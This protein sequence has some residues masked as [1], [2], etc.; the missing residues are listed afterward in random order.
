[1][2]KHS[3]RLHEPNPE[4]CGGFFREI[5][6]QN[7]HQ[8][9]VRTSACLSAKTGD[10]GLFCVK[11]GASDKY[12]VLLSGMEEV[13]YHN[14]CEYD[15]SIG[16]GINGMGGRGIGYI[17]NISADPWPTIWFSIGP[18]TFRKELI[19]SHVEPALHVRYTLE[20]GASNSEL[21]VRPLLAFRNS[22]SFNRYEGS[23]PFNTRQ[24]G[25][26][27]VQIKVHNPVLERLWIQCSGDSSFAEVPEWRFNIK[28][29]NPY[30]EF[31]L[32]TEDLYSPGAF[33]CKLPLAGSVVLSF[34][35]LQE[36]HDF[37]PV[38]EMILVSVRY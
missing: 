37:P 14:H 22:V 18:V 13:L 12:Q 32:D 26:N 16:P 3:S 8:V 24:T 30:K 9:M 21:L 29:K 36:I 1:M 34:S 4:P 15:L 23:T 28:Y 5:L 35:T 17:R 6:L 31:D 25:P 7:E 27:Q 10:Q 38:E 11:S 2:A 20:E 19:L 33:H